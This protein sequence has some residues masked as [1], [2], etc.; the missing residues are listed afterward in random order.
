M[1]SAAGEM[2]RHFENVSAS[3][4]ALRTT[5]EEPIQYI[6]DQ[7]RNEAGIQGADIGCGGGRYDLLLLQNIPDLHLICSD[8]NEAMVQEAAAY[9]D[10]HG[11]K[12]FSVQTSVASDLRLAD[13]G[14]NFICTFNAI[15]HFDPVVFLDQCGKALRQQGIVFVYTRLR[16]QNA[17]NLW[18]RFFPDFAEKETRLYSLSQI[19]EWTARV[20]VPESIRFFR[21]H[22]TASLEQLIH[23][24]EGRHYSTFSL[25][26]EK[27]FQKALD[28]FKQ[29]IRENFSDPERI[30]WVDENVMLTFRKT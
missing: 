12:N 24:A 26:K 3:Y 28:S 4:N 19:E 22:R 10:K 1:D 25:Y 7:M 30:Q 14:L 2:Y 20:L 16:T 23:Q 13:K 21:F 6:R 27:E 18:G 9:L 8:V 5:D 29:K 11:Q 15:H 17:R